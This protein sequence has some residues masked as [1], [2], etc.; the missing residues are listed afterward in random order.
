M[1][2]IIIS[3]KETKCLHTHI[4]LARELRLVVNKK[5]LKKYKT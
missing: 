1:I 5:Y 4:P 2:I 3:D